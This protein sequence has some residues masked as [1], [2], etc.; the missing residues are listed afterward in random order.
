MPPPS[1]TRGLILSIL[2]DILERLS[3][4]ELGR[5]ENKKRKRKNKTLR[6]PSETL[7]G[8][9]AKSPIRKCELEMATLSYSHLRIG[10][11]HTPEGT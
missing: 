11:G 5:G 8:G 2:S 1:S 7:A 3:G 10:H 6:F 4:D 9:K